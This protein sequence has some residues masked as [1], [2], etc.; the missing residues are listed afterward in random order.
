V[1]PQYG[2]APG[3]IFILAK[4]APLSAQAAPAVVRVSIVR[5][6]RLRR[7]RQGQNISCPTCFIPAPIFLYPS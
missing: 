1:F 2:E 5:R 3:V 4:P 7:A 6:D